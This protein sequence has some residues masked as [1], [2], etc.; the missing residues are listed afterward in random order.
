MRPFEE[1]LELLTETLTEMGSLVAQSVHR[2]VFSLIDQNSD[3]AHQ[4]IRDDIRIKQMEIKIDDMATSL[5]VREQPVARDMRLVVAAIKI[6][7]D[8]SRMGTLSV[9]IVERTI[10]LIR[11][12]AADQGIDFAEVVNLVESMVLGCLDAFVKRDPDLAL[13]IVKS[14]DSVDKLRNDITERLLEQMQTDTSVIRQGLDHLIIVRSLE[15]IADH[16]TNIAEDTI[17]LVQGIDVRHVAA[18]A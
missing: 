4:V 7:T 6:N 11:R 12:P 16:A 18:P 2:S 1:E 17:F 14:G 13:D 9:N 3:L 15:R 10:P 5:I 8:L